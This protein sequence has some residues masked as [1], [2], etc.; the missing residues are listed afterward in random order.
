MVFRRCGSQPE[1]LTPW[2]PLPML[3][4]GEK[5]PLQPR[6]LWIHR[7]CGS[8]PHIPGIPRSRSKGPHPPNP[9][10]QC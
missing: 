5:A 4:E 2:P 1:A 3:G 7:R 9:L 10:S 6:I 8:Q